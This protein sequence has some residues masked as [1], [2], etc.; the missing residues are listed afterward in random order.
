MS[1]ADPQSTPQAGMDDQHAFWNEV[2]GPKWVRLQARIEPTLAPIGAATI[3]R[4]APKPGERVLDVGSGCGET[5]LS[6]AERIGPDGAVTGVD[7]SRPMLELARSRATQTGAAVT[8]IEANAQSH[9]FEADSFDAVFSRFG[10]MFFD[11]FRAAFANLLRATRPGGRM[12]LGAW[13]TRKDNPWAM[14][15]VPIARPYVELPPRPAPGDPGQFAF[16]DEDFVRGFLEGSGWSNVDF[17]RFDA[18]LRVGDTVDDAA[19]FLIEM[20]PVAAP[21][22]AADEETRAAVGRE[23]RAALEAHAGRD[24]V[25]LGSSCWIIT[26]RKA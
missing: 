15:A 10:V 7:I 6:I 3:E 23:L 9:T 25:H 16:E 19:D 14:T 2:Q 4:L 21:L 26:A 13:R 18:D 22:A 12:A 5:S 17:E 1:P 8:F 24:G 20:G 11:D